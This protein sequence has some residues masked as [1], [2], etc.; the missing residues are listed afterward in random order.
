MQFGHLVYTFIL[1]VCPCDLFSVDI[2]DVDI[3]KS[4]PHDH[5]SFQRALCVLIVSVIMFLTS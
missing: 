1:N 4:R 3:K 2:Q 5:N